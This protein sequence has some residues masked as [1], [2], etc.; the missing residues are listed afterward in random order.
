M[1]ASE[2]RKIE[3][4]RPERRGAARQPGQLRHAVAARP[5]GP[6]V[7]HQERT[8]VGEDVGGHEEQRH[9]QP[10]PCPRREADEHVAHLR[11]AGEPEQPANVGLVQG[12]DVA[13]QHAR[14]RQEHHRRRPEAAL[15]RPAVQQDHRERGEAAQLR[16]HREERHER[17][18]RALVG[19]RHPEV[20][21]HRADL[22]AEAGDDEQ[23]PHRRERRPRRVCHHVDLRRPAQA[24]PPAPSPKKVSAELAVPVT[25]SFSPASAPRRGRSGGP[26]FLAQAA[27]A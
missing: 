13:D 11:D 24:R 19:V 26:S 27:S 14:R 6:G 16:R 3:Q 9:R 18:G 7:Q 23:H 25:K 10:R 20:E 17:R 8:E 2:S 12:E 4:R 5:L 21:R 22:E 1:P 15:A